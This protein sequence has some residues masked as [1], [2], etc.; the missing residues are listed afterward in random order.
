[1]LMHLRL[2][3]PTELSDEVVELLES[4]ERSANL[5]VLAGASRSPVGDLVECDVAR[6]LVGV[7]RRRAER[8]EPGKAIGLAGRDAAGQRG[9]HHVSARR[10]SWRQSRCS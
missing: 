6:E 10:G 9:A 1:M 5:T 3:V 8:G 2:T 7:D 4:Q